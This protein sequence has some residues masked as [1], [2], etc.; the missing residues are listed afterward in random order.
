[1]K[2]TIISLALAAILMPGCSTT[3]RN[4]DERRAYISWIAFC[5]NRGYSI[6]DNTFDVTNE[7]LD[8]WCGSVDEEAAFTAAGVE[9]Y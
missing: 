7:Y 8:T 2:K 9:P 4:L 5:A 1:M 3:K 6:N